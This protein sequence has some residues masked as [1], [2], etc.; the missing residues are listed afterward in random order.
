[1]TCTY[2]SGRSGGTTA[3]VQVPPGRP[4]GEAA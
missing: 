3:G 1:V 4:W 2:A